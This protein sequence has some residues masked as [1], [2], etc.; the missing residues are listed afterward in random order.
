MHSSITW[1]SLSAVGY[2]APFG[3][4][5]KV[6]VLSLQQ[7]NCSL[8]FDEEDGVA[9][10]SCVI[11]PCAGISVFHPRRFTSENI[12]ARNSCG[13]DGLR[14]WKRGRIMWQIWRRW[15]TWLDYKSFGVLTDQRLFCL[16]LT[17]LF[18]SMTCKSSYHRLAIGQLAIC[19]RNSQFFPLSLSS[20]SLSICW[21]FWSFSGVPKSGFVPWCWSW[22][23][24][25]IGSLCS[26]FSSILV[27]FVN[28]RTPF[29]T[30]CQ[31]VQILDVVTA[32]IIRCI[33]QLLLAP[34][35]FPLFSF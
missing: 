25:L 16:F 35:K 29:G 11:S 2:R 19:W 4:L 9:V 26:S 6:R 28:R 7:D 3:V 30:W 33:S 1:A 20:F 17:E 24:N 18:A 8:T 23:W 27:S 31:V 22:H 13:C 12:W 21:P 15:G 10:T 34:L 5:R 32:L 14:L